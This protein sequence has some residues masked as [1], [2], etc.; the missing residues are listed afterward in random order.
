MWQEKNRSALKCT[1]SLL[2][3]MGI[4]LQELMGKYEVGE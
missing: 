2:H 4:L 1:Q 3:G